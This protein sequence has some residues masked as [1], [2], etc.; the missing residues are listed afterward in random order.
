MQF[1]RSLVALVAA[2]GASLVSAQTIHNVTVG[3]GG[4]VY[5]PNQIT[6][7]MGDIVSFE[8]HPANHTLTQNTFAAPCVP[9]A[10]GVTSGFLPVAATATAFPVFSF[11][12]NAATPLWFHCGQ[13]GHCAAGMVFAIN[14]NTSTANSFDA[15]V[16]NAK[17]SASTTASVSGSSSAVSATT[18]AGAVTGAT[19]A[20]T[21][22]A[23]TGSASANGARESKVIS[24]GL[25]LL[26][27]AVAV[28]IM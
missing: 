2:T 6:A 19:T 4:L 16:T 28:I 24:A 23:T 25:S 12:V 20:A 7:A 1:S 14:V 21:T 11:M 17:G 8:F 18:S 5:N 9:L 26:A 15:Y 27:I 13:T 22:T 10:G 3:V